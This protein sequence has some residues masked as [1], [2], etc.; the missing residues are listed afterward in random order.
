M[1]AWSL[2]VNR[3]QRRTVEANNQL[4]ESNR[5]W[6]LERGGTEGSPSEAVSP[7]RD[8][9]LACR[10]PPSDSGSDGRGEHSPAPAPVVKARRPPPRLSLLA[11]QQQEQQAPLEVEA[12][13]GSAGSLWGLLAGRSHSGLLA[14]QVSPAP[15][16][17]HLLRSP[18]LGSPGSWTRAEVAARASPDAAGWSGLG[19]QPLPLRSLSP[20]TSF[21][22]RARSGAPEGIGSHGRRSSWVA[23]Q[24]AGAGGGS[25]GGSRNNRSLDLGSALRTSSGSFS[26]AWADFAP[27]P[28][29]G[30]QVSLLAEQQQQQQ[31]QQDEGGEVLGRLPS[32]SGRAPAGRLAP[33]SRMVQGLGGM[34]A[35]GRS[36][37]RSNSAVAPL[38][39]P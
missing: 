22:M 4:M 17:D 32:I 9:E 6:V 29:G 37:R 8:L 18:S 31:Q 14:N 36:S 33:L 19:Y 21:Y 5:R 26:S 16:G 28:S 15:S 24:E 3:W 7:P 35:A 20:Q 1:F 38:D 11:Q 27:Q 10:L 25:L 39:S 12:S 34:L 23:G 30:S 2:S 13:G